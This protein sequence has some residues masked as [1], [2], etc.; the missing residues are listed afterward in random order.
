MQFKRDIRCYIMHVLSLMVIGAPCS[1]AFS[2]NAL[3]SKDQYATLS[4]Y[5]LTLS[6]GP[7]WAKNGGNQVFYFSTDVEK[8]FTLAKKTQTLASGELFLGLQRP[9]G[10]RFSGQL[11]FALSGISTTEFSGDVW[12]DASP[13]FNNYTYSYKVAHRRLALKAKFAADFGLV[14]QPYF[15]GSIGVGLNKTYDYAIAAKTPE[16]VPPAP[17]ASQR[18]NALS[19][20]LVAGLQ[21]SITRHWQVGLGY[22]FDD[23]GRSALGPSPDQT[24]GDRLHLGR[25]YSHQLQGSLSFL[26]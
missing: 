4:T 26:G 21:K 2:F 17:F 6:A 11:G 15:G 19:Y 24:L 13:L 16:E 7:A 25:F 1:F 14:V 8:L 9:L 5:L 23:W 3:Y 20:S 22:E 12:E 18:N 10:S